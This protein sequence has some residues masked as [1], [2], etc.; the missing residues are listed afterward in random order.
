MGYIYNVYR[1]LARELLQTIFKA[2]KNPEIYM[3]SH[4]GE[5]FNMSTQNSDIESE[6]LV[7][8][9]LQKGEL[10]PRGAALDD[11]HD[12]GVF[13]ATIQ[14]IINRDR[15]RLYLNATNA[16]EYW[17][18]RLRATG[19]ALAGRPVITENDPLK[20]YDRFQPLLKGLVV[21]DSAVPATLNVGTS[22]AG[23]DDLAL[24]R[25]DNRPES[26]YQRLRHHTSAP[27]VVV[28][29]R[30]LFRGSGTIAGTN[31][32]SSGSAKCDAYLWLI[33]HYIKQRRLDYRWAGYLCDAWWLRYPRGINVTQTYNRDWLTARKSVVFDLSNWADE[34]PVD[35]RNQPLGTDYETLRELFRTIWNLHNG[36]GITQVCGFT[37]WAWKYTNFDDPNSDAPGSDAGG[38]H[39]P[40]DTE[41]DL[42]R[43]LSS[44]NAVIDGDAI[45]HATM[46]NATV[47]GHAGLKQRRV[48]LPAP[49]PSRLRDVGYWDNRLV[50]PGFDDNNHVGGW[51]ASLTDY[52]TVTSPGQ[53]ESGTNFL[54]CRA[55]HD[56]PPNSVSQDVRVNLR[57]GE[58]VRAAVYIRAADGQGTPVL[59]VW[60]LGSPVENA[61]TSRTIHMADGWLRLEVSLRATTAHSTVRLEVYLPVGGPVFWLD[62][63]SLWVEGRPVGVSQRHY[64]VWHMGDYDSAA[65]MY[66]NLPR[67]W[68]DPRRGEVPL[69]W[70]V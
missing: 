14:G 4:F 28:D 23:A 55:T 61:S 22:V 32:S 10:P 35:D 30:G 51:K 38:S 62:S 1:R 67:I 18:N 16:D 33:E 20:I 52:N 46:A 49:T 54:S 7:R 29:L 26:L 21:W 59:A 65:W 64:V 42:A 70:G 34:K 63:A 15:P 56:A 43:I 60:G 40:V 24:V 68:N 53:S 19:G 9:V 31:R 69:A 3:K 12:I 11:W 6:A 47:F 8:V 27:I 2:N 58:S 44:Y 13:L 39:G 36:S 50:N 41:W 5:S 25:Y 48:P 17:W 57:A 66:Q 45:G 37:P